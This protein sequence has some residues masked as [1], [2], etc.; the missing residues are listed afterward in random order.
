MS[1][2]HPDLY[3]VWATMETATA[4]VGFA[5][6][7]QEAVSTVPDLV[8][9]GA[10]QMPEWVPD[11]P[12]SVMRLTPIICRGAGVT[13]EP[14]DFKANE[15]APDYVDFA[16]TGAKDL[17]SVR[18][19]VIKEHSR[20]PASVA[21]AQLAMIFNLLPF[22][23]GVA[24]DDVQEIVQDLDSKMLGG[25]VSGVNFEYSEPVRDRITF[26]YLDIPF[27]HRALTAVLDV[28]QFIN[29]APRLLRPRLR[30]NVSGPNTIAMMALVK[31]F[32][33]ATQIP[34]VS[35]DEN[36]IMSLPPKQYIS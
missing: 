25:V 15:F 10:F 19:R 20:T 3:T 35:V 30:K 33:R 14:I 29:S 2:I 32:D 31:Q 36:V 12:Y 22:I 28:E 16:R 8:R 4:A 6:G 7:S 18:G 23:D 13:V 5:G 34:A 11:G 26:S 17:L 9:T 1:E 24:L 27:W 21:K